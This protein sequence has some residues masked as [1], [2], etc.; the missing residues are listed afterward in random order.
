MTRTA[1]PAR[2]T[3]ASRR[4]GYSIA[5]LVNL[6]LLVAINVWPGWERVPFLTDET[7]LVLGWVNASIV[8]NLVANV[9]Y[10]VA[11]P[12]RLRALGDVVTTSVGVVAMI[13][14]WQVFPF[15]V[16]SDSSGW[17][18]VLRFLLAIGV[19]GSVVGIVA[20]LVRLVSGART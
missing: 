7:D 11:D 9:L 2:R 14:V 15:D 6:A 4:A 13:R 19:I 18:L 5:V 20:A 17:G 16:A 12:P 3:R 8:V 1:A 10:F